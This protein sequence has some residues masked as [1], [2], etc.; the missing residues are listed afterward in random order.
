MYP[1]FGV[2]KTHLSPSRLW[3]TAAD[4]PFV[5]SQETEHLSHGAHTLRGC[6][7][8]GVGRVGP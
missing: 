8:G 7:V 6:Q 2:Q 5:G 1:E 3:E 4:S